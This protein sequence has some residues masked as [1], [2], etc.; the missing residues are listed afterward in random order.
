MNQKSVR[1]LQ[2]EKVTRLIIYNSTVTFA[3]PIY[4]IYFT[5]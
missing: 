2:E 4:L 3:A 1:Y 5:P